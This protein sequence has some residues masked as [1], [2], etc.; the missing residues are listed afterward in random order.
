MRK[1]VKLFALFL[2]F[3]F[4]T[5]CGQNQTNVPKDNIKSETKDKATSPGSNEKY[6]TK[7]EYTDSIGKSLVI[8]NSVRKGG[9]YTDPK[10]ISYGKVIFWTRLINETDNPLELKIDLP[11]DSIEVP[12]LPGKYYKL[13]VPPDTM[14]IDKE[15]LYDYGMTGV[16]SFLDNNIHKPSYLK[17]TINPKE[18]SGFYVVILFEHW[19]GAPFGA[20]LSIKGQNLVYRISRYESKP[21]GSMVYEKEINC[22]SINLKNLKLK[23]FERSGS[24]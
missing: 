14:T 24:F 23:T 6:P 17:R 18:S 4:H 10:G 3:V 22:G 13:F 9:P 20:E 5:S 2:M 1:L 8:Q 16:K 7:Y 19:M 15:L 11:A 12:G 21:A